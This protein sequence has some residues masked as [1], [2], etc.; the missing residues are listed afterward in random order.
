MKAAELIK[1]LEKIIEEVGNKEIFYQKRIKED[2]EY[3]NIVDTIN[4][5][6]FFVVKDP[7]QVGEELYLS[8]EFYNIPEN[9]EAIIIATTDMDCIEDY[10]LILSDLSVGGVLENDFLKSHENITKLIKIGKYQEGTVTINP[11]KNIIEKNELLKFQIPLDCFYL[12][13]IL[14]DTV[15]NIY[16]NKEDE[17]ISW[18]CLVK[19]VDNTS[20]TEETL[21]IKTQDE[22][23]AFNTE[24]CWYKA[25]LNDKKYSKAEPI[26]EF[27][28]IL[29]YFKR[30]TLY[31]QNQKKWFKI[32][33]QI[34]AKIINRNFN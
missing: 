21:F 20:D 28:I 9:E 22:I 23:W 10:D 33:F 8:S 25:N 12:G 13:K 34:L 27:D 1:A 30:M 14:P 19:K 6:H 17:I 4:V 26:T 15:E 11:L 16:Y 24:G 32:I 5:S 7:K 2:G 18:T 29:G 3:Y 31:E